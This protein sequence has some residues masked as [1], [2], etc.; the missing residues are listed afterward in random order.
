M[1]N[2]I[3][4]LAEISIKKGQDKSVG[5]IEKNRANGEITLKRMPE[6]YGATGQLNAE[7]SSKVMVE[8]YGARG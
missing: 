1:P 6:Y 3:S 2:D 4:C 5:D 7:I 8:Y